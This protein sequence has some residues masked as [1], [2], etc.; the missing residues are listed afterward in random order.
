MRK[1]IF[2]ILLFSFITNFAQNI[3]PFK[4]Y[5]EPLEINELGG[6]QS[7]AWAQHDG[8]WL[9]IGGRLDGL[10]RRQPWASFDIE[11]HN[12]QIL[13]IDPKAKKKWSA[14]LKTLPNPLQEQLSSTN[15]EFFQDGNNL[16]LVGGY[17]YSFLET[18]HI[19]FPYL[20]MVNIPG[21]IEAVINN[22]P[23]STYFNQ[24][25][26]DEKFAVT[27]GYLNKIYDTYYL[28][29]GQKFIGRYNPMGP[30]NGPGFIQEYTNAIRKFK[31]ELNGNEIK[32]SHFPEIVD[33]AN[34]HRR[35][36]NVIPQI[37]PSGKEGLTAFSGVFQEKA[38]LPFLNCVNIDSSGYTVN[39]DFIQHFNHYHCAHIPLYS[40]KSSEMHNLFFGGIAQF[41]QKNGS[42]VQ[43]NNVPFVKS[44]ARVS[45][46]AQGKMTEFLLPLE[47]PAFLGASSEF[48]V[49]PSIEQYDNGV[50]KLDD[51][52]KD[53]TVI[54]Y[55][56]GGISSTASNIF[57]SNT[58]NES[59]ANKQ[60]FK[61][62]LIKTLTTETQEIFDDT[63]YSF[64]LVVYPNPSNGLLNTKFNLLKQSDVSIL[65]SDSSGK[66]L[67]HQNFNNLKKG[68]NTIEM[69]TELIGHQSIFITLTTN[70][71]NTTQKV[72][73]N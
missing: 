35:D 44:I 45:R 1:I 29:G 22:A 11:G 52:N 15:M 70:H 25:K 49:L 34:L 48:I 13:V 57:F 68:M 37:M 33:S 12:T 6:L 24:I 4:V 42:L 14:P 31:L 28:T 51:L 56:F 16:I 53:T 19:T 26:K 23:I 64:G 7:Y 32:V 72:I 8:K 43:D 65:F 47:M 66:I 36:F 58:D 38:D 62:Y 5:L 10:H 69:N 46:D 9:L 67:K 20:T 17:G 30:N 21:L 18:N 41:Y 54:G 2:S 61:V 27:G 3:D 59:S 71:G 55:I 73:L 63:T 39:N 60:L 50:I 40:E